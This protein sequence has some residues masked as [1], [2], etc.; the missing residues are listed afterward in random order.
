ELTHECWLS[1]SRIIRFSRGLRGMQR[2]ATEYYGGFWSPVSERTHLITAKWTFAACDRLSSQRT[3]LMSR[4]SPFLIA[5]RL[6][7]L[8]RCS[9]WGRQVYF[10]C[11]ECGVESSPC[12]DQYLDGG[13]ADVFDSENS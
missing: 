5:H 3:R 9:H 6:S 10:P 7:L 1:A 8:V 2:Y 13:V 11:L 12:V 4:T